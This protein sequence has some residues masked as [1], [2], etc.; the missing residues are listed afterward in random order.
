MAKVGGGISKVPTKVAASKVGGRMKMPAAGR[1]GAG[2]GS[3]KPVG[4]AAATPMP[5][6]ALATMAA[7]AGEAGVAGPSMSDL[8]GPS[9][10]PATP[11]QP[12]FKKPSMGMPGT[13]KGK[14][15]IFL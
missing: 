6:N 4:G 2:L 14:G 3:M 7:A 13:K 1:V 15:S 11:A 9:A 12:S 5:S 10:V 8:S